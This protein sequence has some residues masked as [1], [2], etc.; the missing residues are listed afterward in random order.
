[1]PLTES[2]VFRWEMFTRD[3][4]KS[5]DGMTRLLPLQSILEGTVWGKEEKERIERRK[6]KEVQFSLVCYSFTQTV[7]ST[8]LL[9]S[10]SIQ[11]SGGLLLPFFAW[12]RDEMEKYSCNMFDP[13]LLVIELFKMLQF[14]SIWQQEKEK[15]RWRNNIGCFVCVTHFLSRSPLFHE[16]KKIET[17]IHLCLSFWVTL[18]PFLSLVLFYMCIKEDSTMKENPLI[19]TAFL[20]QCSVVKKALTSSLAS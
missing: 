16:Y 19:L 2:P 8:V 15:T 10:L 4:S 11:G 3:S 17:V 7:A 18:H 13:L 9:F 12:K 5:R 1:M 6:R 20:A 14:K